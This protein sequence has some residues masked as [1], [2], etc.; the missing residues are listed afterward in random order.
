MD[1]LVGRAPVDAALGVLDV[2][3][4]GRDRR[5]DQSGTRRSLLDPVVD[6]VG[7]GRLAHSEMLQID[8]AREPVEQRLTGSEHHRAMMSI[9]S[10]TMPASRAWQMTSAPPMTSTCLPAVGEHEDRDAPWVLPAPMAC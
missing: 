5:G 8:R 2:A 3:V 6:E 1:L 7:E 4:Q 9:N 10:S